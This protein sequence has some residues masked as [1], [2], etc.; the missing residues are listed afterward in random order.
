[1]YGYQYR[2]A[3]VMSPIQYQPNFEVVMLRHASGF[4]ELRALGS[5]VS[6]LETSRVVR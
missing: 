6:A 2:Q 4:E 3:V 5:E 1:M